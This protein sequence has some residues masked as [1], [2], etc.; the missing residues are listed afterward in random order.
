MII[1]ETDRLILRHIISQDIDSLLKIYNKAENMRFISNGK[2]NWTV[3]ELNKK[4]ELINRNYKLGFGIYAI[5]Q[6]ET[7]SIIGEI[8]LFD[9]FND[10]SN[11]EIGYIIDSLF[12]NKGFGKEACVGLLDY[13]FNK[14]KVETLTA[15]MYAENINSIELSKKCGMSKIKEG[16][17]DNGAKFLVFE[18]KRIKY[19]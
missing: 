12:W 19:P 16:L 1:L 17:T 3:E 18:I 6:K 8:G 9:S 7:N 2:S 5:E 15:R 11:L 13:A 4:Y 10:N 14:L